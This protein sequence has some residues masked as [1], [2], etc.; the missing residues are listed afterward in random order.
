[1]PVVAHKRR[2]STRRSQ[3][4][5]FAMRVRKKQR[6]RRGQFK[7]LPDFTPSSSQGFIQ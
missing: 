5:A 1:M 7:R 4:A 3:G 2:K 6:V